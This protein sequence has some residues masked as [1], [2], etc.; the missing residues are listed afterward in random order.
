[1]IRQMVFKPHVVSGIGN[2]GYGSV[3]YGNIRGDGGG[4][5]CKSGC[6]EYDGSGQSTVTA[7]AP[8]PD[9][10]ADEPVKC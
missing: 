6:S 7:T 1:M 5:G 8:N 10:Y 9:D 4:Y 3:A 2:T